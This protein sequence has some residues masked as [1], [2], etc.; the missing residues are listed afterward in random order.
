MRVYL[1][2]VPCFLRQALEAVRLASQDLSIQE[3][4]IRV[5]LQKLSKISW[6]TSP[7]HIGREIH[8]LI[9]EVTGN[10]DPYLPLKKRFN[11]LAINLYPMLE[12][13]VK[14]A[15]DP[16][17]TAVRL[18]LAGNM[19]DFGARPGEKIDIEKE[20][21]GA[22]KAPLDKQA[23]EKFKKAV[24]Q[25]Q[26]ILFLG[27][28]AGEVVFD[29]LLVQEIG[30]Q[31][32]TYVVKKKPIINDATLEDAEIVNLTKIVKVI[33]NGTDF[34][35]T[36]LSACSK[37]FTNIYEKA[38]LVIAKGQG[39]YETL[40]DVKKPIVFLLKIKCPVIAKDIKRNVGDLV[41]HLNIY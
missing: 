25:A 26:N 15:N 34:P 30:P 13:K 11:Q 38:D 10:P 40:N 31:K 28:N 6:N 17:G 39:N 4:A 35:G 5:I 37:T 29:K 2:C 32:I 41:I 22:L 14:T 19:I 12:K 24:T 8:T 7:P 36:V 16:F 27:D 1:D 18:S 9:K 33:D 21:N 23:L 20:I 3:K